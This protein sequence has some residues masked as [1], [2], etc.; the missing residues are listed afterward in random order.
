MV[1]AVLFLAYFTLQQMARPAGT[2]SMINSN[3]FYISIVIILLMIAIPVYQY[4]LRPSSR[5]RKKLEQ[6]NDDLSEE[7]IE[8]L[9]EQYQ[10]I[11][12]LYLKL[13]EKEKQNFYGRVDKIREEIEEHLT[14]EKKIEEL[15]ITSSKGTIKERKKSYDQLYKHYRHLPVKSKQKHY[16]RIVQLREELERGRI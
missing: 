6:V 10:E 15:S 16:P 1:I 11:H 14:C 12:R 8:T 4:F 3:L 5:L 2:E 9:K 13:S 7:T